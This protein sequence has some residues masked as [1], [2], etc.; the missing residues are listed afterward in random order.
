MRLITLSDNMPG[1]SCVATIGFFDGVHSGHHFLIRQVLR[2]A[3]E[4][5]LASLLV[6]FRVH[7]R[8]VMCSD[9]QPQLL[10]T[11]DE[12]CDLLS[13]TGADYCATL[14]FT[15]EMAAL[16]ARQFMSDILKERLGVKVL[17]IGYDHRF[18][19]DR[20][21]GF[22]D[23][24]RY[25]CE[26]G[27]EVV[28]AEAFTM[29]E[30]HVSSSMIRALLTEG[31]VE[32]AARCLTHLYMLSG[33]VVDGFRVGRSLGFPTA[34][35]QVDDLH[36]LIPKDGVY[37]VRVRGC[38]DREE[39]SFG[40]MLNIGFRPTIE[41]GGNRTIEVYL[42]DFSGDLYDSRLT[43]E[44]VSRLRDEKKFRSKGELANQ[45]RADEEA[46]RR[47]FKTKGQHL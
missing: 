20:S 10:S 16:S 32:M 33:K 14:D 15:P 22:A 41:N 1:Q 26:L 13:R 18:G 5:G 23:Y 21:E 43:V 42:L 30:V 38:F 3:A 12:K 46:V 34:N 45:L 28:R 44:F 8:Q 6:T 36:K 17:V 35:L 40:G 4:R 19:H 25:G 7:P 37:A 39:R 29:N 24:V 9:Y 31:E 47:I 11:Y 2:C 27:I